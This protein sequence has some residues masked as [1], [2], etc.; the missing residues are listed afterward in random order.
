MELL[1]ALRVFEFGMT[2]AP[3]LLLDAIYP[4]E[5]KRLEGKVQNL[6]ELNYLA[7]RL[8]SFDETEL[9]AFYEAMAQRKY[10]ELKDLINLTFNL[11]QYAL[12]RDISSYEQVGK[13]YLL[14]TEGILP[15]ND[16]DHE[17]YKEVGRRLLESGRGLVT[18]HGL[19][20]YD[21]DMKMSEIYDGANFPEYDWLANSLASAEIRYADK[22]ETVFL[23]ND[24]AAILKV[25]GRLGADSICRTSGTERKHHCT[26]L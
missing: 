21:P 20:F 25:L 1:N 12:I 6:D 17:K 5:L 11:N 10:D 4:Q 14:Q 24:S 7:K 26:P 3:K 16:E 2:E 18:E 9:S 8:D 22:G 13:S 19:L 23:P 15:A